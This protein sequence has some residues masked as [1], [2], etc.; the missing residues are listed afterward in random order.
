MHPPAKVSACRA[1]RAPASS[2]TAPDA[3]SHRPR[4]HLTTVLG[5]KRLRSISRDVRRS[6]EF[7]RDLLY[8]P[9]E[10]LKRDAEFPPMRGKRV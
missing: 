10:N 7:N 8:E 2:V 9:D 3:S 6:T 5:V 1:E 4:R